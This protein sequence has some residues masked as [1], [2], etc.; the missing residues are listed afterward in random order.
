MYMVRLKKVHE[1]LRLRPGFSSYLLF[2]INCSRSAWWQSGIVSWDLRKNS[3]IVE[4]GKI[5][6]TISFWYKALHWV[7]ANYGWYLMS[8]APFCKL[9]YLFL[10]L[11][12]IRFFKVFEFTG[13]AGGKTEDA[14]S[15]FF[16][17]LHR[18]VSGKRRDATG[19]LIDE[20]AKRPPVDSLAIPLTPDDVRCEVLWRPT[21]R[22]C[23]PSHA[24]CP[25]KTGDLE[26]ALVI[27]QEIFRF[28]VPIDHI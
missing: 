14:R 1:C 9:P 15:C 22:P 10:G 11:T 16:E 19:E 24:F 23:S 12:W 13:E 7:D 18:L 17:Y 20:D 21:R 5:G 27:K 2:Q 28:Q 26:V 8:F 4:V 6:A 3:W 25:L